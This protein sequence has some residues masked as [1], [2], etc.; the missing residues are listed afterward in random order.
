MKQGKPSGIAFVE[1]S[2]SK[3]AQKAIQAE[4]GADFEGR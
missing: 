3:E 2:T 1:Y 4:N